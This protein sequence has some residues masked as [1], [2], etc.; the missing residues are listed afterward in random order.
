M[1][2]YTIDVN[3][4][5]ED[6]LNSLDIAAELLP[7]LDEN[8]PLKSKD[9]LEYNYILNKLPV[10]T[11]IFTKDEAWNTMFKIYKNWCGSKIKPTK[12]QFLAVCEDIYNFYN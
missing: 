5:P 7:W 1:Q 2:N 10:F 11:N 12:E 3:I 9:R 8:I 4:D 6:V